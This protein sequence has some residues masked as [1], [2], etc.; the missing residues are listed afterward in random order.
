MDQVL[1]GG[2]AV[3]LIHLVRRVGEDW[4]IECMPNM[5]ELHA[6]Q[7]HPHYQRT[8]DVRAATCPACKTTAAS[9]R[10]GLPA[11]NIKGMREE[12]SDG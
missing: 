2:S 6:T 7:Y 1:V 4:R 3:T 11:A 12:L 10:A 8:D 5:V 9:A